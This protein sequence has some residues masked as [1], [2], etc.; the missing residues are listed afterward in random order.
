MSILTILQA[1]MSSTRLP[2]KVLKPMHGVPMM[3]RQI[4]RLRHSAHLGR[5]VVATSTDPGDD[6]IET[7]CGT[8]SV[9]VHRGPLQNVLG[10]YA[11][12]LAAFGPAE[13]VV[14]VTADCPLTDWTIIDEVI[15]LH[16]ASGAD[17]TSNTVERTYAKGLD[18]EIFRAALLPQIAASATDPYDREHV[19]P[20][21]YR[22]PDR[23]TIRQLTQATDQSEVRWTVDTPADYRL[24]RLVYD[25]L[26]DAKPAF[27]AV[28]VA[29]LGWTLQA[30]PDEAVRLSRL[31]PPADA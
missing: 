24:A 9:P 26:Y 29:A 3:G 2:G 10:R 27:T 15:S 13:H 1:R 12:A 17:Y 21:F 6:V 14:R 4:E 19:T 23:F 8:L 7:Y 22:N 5:L 25:V 16:L 11:G 28:D 18:V 20:H 31:P 30:D